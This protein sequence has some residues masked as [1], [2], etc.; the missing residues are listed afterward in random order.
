MSNLSF[1]SK[2][3][4]KLVA[5]RLE[6]HLSSHRLHYNLQ[7]A[8]RTGHS[9]ET[10][11]LNVHHDIAEALDRKCMAALVLLDLSAA[12]DVIDHKIL[13]TRLEHSFG[14]TGSALSWIKCFMCDRSQCVA[15]GMTTSEGTCLNFGVAQR[16]VL[17]PRKYCL[18]SKSI[19]AICSRY[20]L[21]YH[22]YADDTQVYIA[23]MP[24]TTWSDVTKK[25]EACLADIS[26]TRIRQS[27]LSLSQNIRL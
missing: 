21:L 10:A 14:V 25:L 18:Y 15:I 1:L 13:Q 12:F 8:Y 17:G 6:T 19:G 5:K 2:I 9:T 20:N 4:E 3:L 24:K 22:C 26:E 23:I 7:S 11:L 27:S 16:S